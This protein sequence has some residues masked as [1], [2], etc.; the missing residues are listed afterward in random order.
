MEYTKGKWGARK[1]ALGTWTIETD[2]EYI[3]QIDRHL[4]AE[5]IVK[6][7]NCHD[8]LVEALKEDNRALRFLLEDIS[9]STPLLRA[10]IQGKI[11]AGEKSLAKA[12][13]S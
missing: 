12:E 6:A 13:S 3:G 1:N 4:N 10:T 8:D 5:R 11:T 2:L 9:S 7:V